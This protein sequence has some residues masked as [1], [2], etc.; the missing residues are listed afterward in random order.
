[1]L[2]YIDVINA[3]HILLLVNP[4]FPGSLIKDPVNNLYPTLV[5][6]A[7]WIYDQAFEDSDGYSTF[8]LL[9]PLLHSGHWYLLGL[10]L[11]ILQGSHKFRKIFISIGWV[12]VLLVLLLVCL[13]HILPVCQWL[14]KAMEERHWNSFHMYYK[15]YMFL[16]TKSLNR[17]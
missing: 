14:R 2:S 8:Y 11:Q 5:S 17:R 7:H 1:M 15:K 16:R 12:G 10:K 6:Y 13:P 4:P 9:H 3:A